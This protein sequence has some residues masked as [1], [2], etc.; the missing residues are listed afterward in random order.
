MITSKRMI[1]SKLIGLSREGNKVYRNNYL[2]YFF[3]LVNFRQTL[4]CPSGKLRTEFTGLL[5]KYPLALGYLTLYDLSLNIGDDKKVVV[6]TRQ[7]FML[8]QEE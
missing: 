6:L 7:Y 1:S 8:E 4:S 3:I 5:V 2:V